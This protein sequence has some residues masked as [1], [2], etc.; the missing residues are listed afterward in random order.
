MPVR[1]ISSNKLNLILNCK[2]SGTTWGSLS[3]DDSDA[4]ENG[5]KAADLD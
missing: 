3:N 5:E 1:I 2:G 4:K